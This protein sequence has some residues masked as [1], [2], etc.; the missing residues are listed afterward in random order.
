[1]VVLGFVGRKLAARSDNSA[2]VPAG[3]VGTEY[4]TMYRTWRGAG[5]IHRSS[6]GG[7]WTLAMGKTW[8]SPCR[9]DSNEPGTWAWTWYL[10]EV[11][12]RFVVLVRETSRHPRARLGS[13]LL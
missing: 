3:T 9:K 10:P 1:M 12:F 11:A 4:N 7:P 6:R 8:Q 5:D 13:R 2:M